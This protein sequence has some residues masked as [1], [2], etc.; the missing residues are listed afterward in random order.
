MRVRFVEGARA[1]NNRAGD[2]ELPA[3]GLRVVEPERAKQTE[4]L[5]GLEALR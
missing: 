3:A 4:I 1:F 5:V 2:C